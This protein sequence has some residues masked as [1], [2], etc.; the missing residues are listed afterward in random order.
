[1][2]F[3]EFYVKWLL[4]FLYK[5]KEFKRLAV[6]FVHSLVLGNHRRVQKA[7]TSKNFNKQVSFLQHVF[8]KIALMFSKLFNA[9]LRRQLQG[10]LSKKNSKL[11]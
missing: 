10:L 9:I 2:D 7:S 4:G 11:A 1:M 8:S 5:A 3:D 6:V